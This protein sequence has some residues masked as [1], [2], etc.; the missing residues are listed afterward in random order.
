MAP[1]E[2]DEPDLYRLL[3]AVRRAME[4]EDGIGEAA[5]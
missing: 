3:D 1:G 2:V 5:E 4:A